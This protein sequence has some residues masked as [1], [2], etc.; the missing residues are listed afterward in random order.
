MN[1]IIKKIN[2]K[3]EINNKIGKINFKDLKILYYGFLPFIVPPITVLSFVE[4][5]NKNKDFKQN[6]NKHM[7]KNIILKDTAFGFFIAM[8]Y[9]ISF[10]YL[11]IKN[12]IC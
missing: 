9:P 12:I 6:K 5:S 7:K 10:P 11:L 1:K 4:S 3:C 2:I 8:T